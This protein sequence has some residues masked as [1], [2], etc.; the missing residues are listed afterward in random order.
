MDS[1]ERGI[2]MLVRLVGAL[3]IVASILEI[4]LY[5]AKCL[6]PKP[7]VPVAVMPFVVSSI[8]AVVGIGVLIAAKPIAE[9]IS[10]LFDD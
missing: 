3:L 7:P 6:L 8:P 9:W 5:L 4:G 2:L 1:F 10:N